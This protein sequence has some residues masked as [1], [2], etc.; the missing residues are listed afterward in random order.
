MIQDLLDQGNWRR[1][2][3]SELFHQANVNGD[4]QIGIEEMVFLL[5]E[6]VD[7]NTAGVKE[8]KNNLSRYLAMVKAG[9]EILIM[10]RGK[11]IARI[12][13]E[14]EKTNSIRFKKVFSGAF[15]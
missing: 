11:P 5:Q 8:I 3:S 10:E 2:D 12:V 7:M 14:N 6:A 4:Q 9:E 1:A 15:F 13:K